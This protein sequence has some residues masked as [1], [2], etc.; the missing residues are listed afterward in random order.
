ML[1]WGAH[2]GGLGGVLG[3]CFYW[4]VGWWC[5]FE[6]RVLGTRFLYF[7]IF[8]RRYCILQHKLESPKVLPFV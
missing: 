5:C 2:E 7:G 1:V 4:P 8:G 3:D 6:I